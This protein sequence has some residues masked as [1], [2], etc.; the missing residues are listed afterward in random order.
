MCAEHQANVGRVKESMQTHP[1]AASTAR[2][3]CSAA[4]RRVELWRAQDERRRRGLGRAKDAGSQ[5][6]CAR[7]TQVKSHSACHAAQRLTRCTGQDTASAAVAQGPRVA[8]QQSLGAASGAAAAAHPR[9]NAW[10]CER[11]R[12]RRQAWALAVAIRHTARQLALQI[13]AGQKRTQTVG[14]V[15]QAARTVQA[16]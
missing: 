4:Q 3:T 14:Q 10:G 15:T 8:P 2:L 13:P 7:R 5:R 12:G 16:D 6:T 11:R 9:G 1:A